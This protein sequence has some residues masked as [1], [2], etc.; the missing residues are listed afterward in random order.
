MVALAHLHRH[1]FKLV[2]SNGQFLYALYA[3]GESR[4]TAEDLL[5]YH[6]GKFNKFC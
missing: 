4:A 1:Q 3:D 5:T 6:S 2:G